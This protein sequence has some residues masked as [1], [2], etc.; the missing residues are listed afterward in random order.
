VGDPDSAARRASGHG[1]SRRAV[2]LATL[3]GLSGAVAAGAVAVENRSLPGRTR[4]NALFGQHDHDPG[5]PAARGGKLVS[6]SF[7]SAARQGRHCGWT[8]A[9]P[10]PQAERLPVVIALHG[11]GADHRS[12]FG[13]DLG[14]DRFLVA[15][16]HRLAIASVDGGD[17]YWHRRASGEDAGAMVIDEFLPLLGEHGLETSRLGLLGWSMG[18]FGALWLAGRLGPR[19]LCAVAAESPAIWHRAGQTAPGAFDDPADFGAHD[20]FS[21][22]GWLTGIALRLDCGTDDGFFPAARDYAELIR[23]K[24]A[25][26][27]E[28]GGHTLA[29]WRSTAP[30]QLS[31]LADRLG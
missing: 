20:V 10:G 17:T 27:F 7:R 18:A 2:L 14:L 21:N 15:G 26:G 1:F 13:N 19:R 6:G 16:G 5:L 25:G 12:A 11:R 29:Y 22:P 3:T 23:P 28:A 24:P 31:F 30:A 8:I 4:L 9:Y